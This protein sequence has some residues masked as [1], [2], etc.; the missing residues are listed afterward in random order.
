MLFVVLR[1]LFVHDPD[2]PNMN[3]RRLVSLQNIA[4]EPALH[5]HL[6]LFPPHQ[7]P[8]KASSLVDRYSSPS[9]VLPL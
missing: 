9:L 2:Q 4:Q 6:Y 8:L 7:P 3:L 5:L 1:L